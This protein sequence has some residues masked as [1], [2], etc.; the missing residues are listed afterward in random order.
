[1]GAIPP[2]EKE[3]YIRKANSSIALSDLSYMLFY[4]D[5]SGKMQAELVTALPDETYTTSTNENQPFSGVVLVEDWHGN[6]LKGFLHKENLVTPVNLSDIDCKI[7]QIEI[8]NVTDYYYCESRDNWITEKCRYMYTSSSCFTLG[9]GGGGSA[10]PD[11]PP[12][13]DDDTFSKRV[14]T[15]DEKNDLI[16]A[17][18]DLL[19]YCPNQSIINAV[20]NNLSFMVYPGIPYPAVAAF[21][22]SANTIYFKSPSNITSFHIVEELFHAYQNTNYSGGIAQYYDKP[23]E[24][25]IEF[26][27]KVYRDLFLLSEGGLPVGNTNFPP[28]E[29]IE[30]KNLLNNIKKYGF[31][32]TVLNQ[33]STVLGY[34]LKYSAYRDGII[35]KLSKPTALIKV[36]NCN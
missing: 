7:E 2:Y 29:S 23:G 9:S 20:W 8:C 34:F 1:M 12:I 36:I 17:K 3:L 13:N 6:Y 18:K 33:Y 35:D 31:T 16:T 11:Y 5:Y 22:P 27:A 28:T 19:R 32:S 15:P 10:D 24:T 21:S 4:V 26:E 25:N 14:L 30:Y